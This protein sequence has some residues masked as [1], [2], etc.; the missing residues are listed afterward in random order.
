[1]DGVIVRDLIRREISY[2]M[3]L[4]D[5][6]KAEQIGISK[7]TMERT[8]KR[9]EQTGAIIK[10][11]AKRGRF[12]TATSPNKALDAL[13]FFVDDSHNSIRDVTQ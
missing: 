7:S 13:L 4:F 1:M 9:F 12:A 5:Q 8:I 10:N 6:K 11:H 2:L 3:K